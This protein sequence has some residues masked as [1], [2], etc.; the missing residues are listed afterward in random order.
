M[1][2]NIFSQKILESV[3]S[4]YRPLAE[5]LKYNR[6]AELRYIKSKISDNPSEV[7]EWFEKEI[8]RLNNFNVEDISK[9]FS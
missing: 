1:F 7:E 9:E 2:T 4:L 6:I 3:I 5:G 8:N